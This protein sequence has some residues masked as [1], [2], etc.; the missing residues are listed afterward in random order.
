M[1][2]TLRL[3]GQMA[4]VNKSMPQTMQKGCVLIPAY[5]EEK[6]IRAVVQQARQYVA[7]VIVVDDGSP[8][9]TSEEAAAAGAVVLRH[10]K[11]LGKGKALNTGFAYAAK[12]NFEF[13]ITMDADGQHAPEDIPSF[14]TAY[15]SMGVSVLVGNRMTAP[16]GMP[17]VRKM[18]NRF[19]SWYLSRGMGQ[20]VPDTQSGYRLYGASVLPYLDAEASR[21][22]AESETLLRLAAHKI[23]IGS[24]PIRVIYRGDEKS[25]IRPFRD[26]WRFF[27]M[28]RRFRKKQKSHNIQLQTS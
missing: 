27:A 8:D 21:Y 18:T 15:R 24:V 16:K 3:A 19:M 6:R 25:K 1:K 23:K 22:A 2:I 26:T 17:F 7:D 5:L 10:E 12:N 14:V 28:V 9:K 11:N 13:I 4:G 20:T